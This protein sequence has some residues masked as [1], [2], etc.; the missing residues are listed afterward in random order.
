MEI[1]L[2]TTV[3]QNLNNK[4][5]ASRH[6]PTRNSLRHSRMIVLNRINGGASAKNPEEFL[7]R[8]LQII[9]YVQLLLGLLIGALV[10]GLMVSLPN[11]SLYPL[12]FFSWIPV[13]KT[14]VFLSH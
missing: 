8:K 9:S 2:C 3:P 6:K 10:I 12:P 1:N 5:L 13:I 4:M 14:Q 11:V 7:G